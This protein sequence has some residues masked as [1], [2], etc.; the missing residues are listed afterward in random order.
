MENQAAGGTPVECNNDVV[1]TCHPQ[2]RTVILRRTLKAP[3][4]LK[5]GRGTD[6]NTP[7]TELPRPLLDPG[8]GRRSGSAP[9][10]REQDPAARR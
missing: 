10:R 8:G 4:G 7:W 2:A 5:P 1:E 3:A 6:R 9:S